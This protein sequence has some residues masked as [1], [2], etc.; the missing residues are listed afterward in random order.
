MQMMLLC[1]ARLRCNNIQGHIEKKSFEGEGCELSPTFYFG[2]F[3]VSFSSQDMGEPPHVHIKSEKGS[4]KV[5]L[6]PVKVARNNGF[7]ERELHK[8]LNTI[9]ENRGWL[10]SEW[11]KFWK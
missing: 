4:A 6:S 11:N 7:N 1:S 8:A 2:E 10:L 5:W 9:Q 3:S